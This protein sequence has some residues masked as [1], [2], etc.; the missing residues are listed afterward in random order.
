MK[1]SLRTPPH[2]LNTMNNKNTIRAALLI[3]SAFTPVAFSEEIKDDK[4]K[5]A[6]TATVQDGS[7]TKLISDSATFATLT[8]ALT[9]TGLDVTLGA[10]GEY[11]IF[12]PTDEAFGKLPSGVLAKL[13]L[14]E[15]KEKLRSLL[16]YH[17]VAGKVMSTDLKDGDV[18]TMNGEKVKVDV[19]DDGIE[20]E[21][22]KVFS[23]DVAASNGVMHSIGTVMVPDSLEGFAGLDK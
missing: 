15:N 7:L 8:K 14:P 1:A 2:H 21:D 6:E 19:E 5:V 4:A 22:S 16:L 9:A 3:L 10:K 23:A 17:V 18:K 12:A 20:V 11:T 13:L